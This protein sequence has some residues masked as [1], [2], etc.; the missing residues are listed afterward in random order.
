MVALTTMSG[1]TEA[2]DRTLTI[3]QFQSRETY[4]G[5][6]RID[7]SELPADA[8]KARVQTGKS[9]RPVTRITLNMDYAIEVALRPA[10]SGRPNKKTTS[11]PGSKG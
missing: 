3:F 8:I 7:T 5:A 6:F 1:C 2:A 4:A 10:G 11:K 9:G